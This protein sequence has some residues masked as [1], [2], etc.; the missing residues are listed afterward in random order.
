MNRP[1]ITIF[2]NIDKFDNITF[3][4]KTLIYMTFKVEDMKNTITFG[5]K[6]RKCG[7]ANWTSLK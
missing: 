2:Y 6:L 1:L 7:P 3:Y 4:S 5:A